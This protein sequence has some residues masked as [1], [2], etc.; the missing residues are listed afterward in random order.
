M[1]VMHLLSPSH[2]PVSSS[3]IR[4]QY[5]S[6]H[7]PP[8]LGRDS[9]SSNGSASVQNSPT[10]DLASFD[11]PSHE[12]ESSDS[13]ERHTYCINILPNDATHRHSSAATSS[14]ATTDDA[15]QISDEPIPIHAID[16]TLSFVSSSPIAANSNFTVLE[17]EVVVFWEMTGLTLSD[18]PPI[19]VGPGTDG[20]LYTTS[21]VPGYWK[22][23]SESSG[24]LR[25]PSVR[26]I[27]F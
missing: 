21:L 6:Q 3:L 24:R 1:K 12:Q 11:F 9:V 25:I 14:S 26:F 4:S 5:D 17:D 15:R 27:S 7:G 19:E 2:R 16:P 18:T 13:H 22:T 20:L 8:L 23:I 10:D